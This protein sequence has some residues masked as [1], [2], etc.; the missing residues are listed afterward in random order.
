MKDK[1]WRDKSERLEVNV[2]FVRIGYISYVEFDLQRI[3]QLDSMRVYPS[4]CDSDAKWDL[5]CK[6]NHIEKWCP[7]EQIINL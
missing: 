6:E 3:P 2:G 1:I 5:F 4:D 7:L